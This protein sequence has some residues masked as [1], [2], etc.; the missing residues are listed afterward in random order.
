MTIQVELYSMEEMIFLFTTEIYMTSS[1]VESYTVGKKLDKNSILR[2]AQLNSFP[3]S[4]R[5]TH[6][7]MQNFQYFNFY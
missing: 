1:K 6:A 4:L 5:N 3:T 7:Y 2:R